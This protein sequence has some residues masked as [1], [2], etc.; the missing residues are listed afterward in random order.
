MGQIEHCLQD[1]DMPENPTKQ[2][3]LAQDLFKVHTL[4]MAQL[5]ICS[6]RV[7]ARRADWNPKTISVTKTPNRMLK[8]VGI[9]HFNAGNETPSN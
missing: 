4:R 7:S 5:A 1:A 3:T 8:R 2:S 9:I 6:V